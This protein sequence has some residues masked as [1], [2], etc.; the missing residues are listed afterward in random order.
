MNK[1]QEK[2][3]DKMLEH[4]NRECNAHYGIG[5]LPPGFKRA[6][7]EHVSKLIKEEYK[8]GYNDCLRK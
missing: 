4:N 7:K 1:E 2:E 5:K 6:I 3:F 8:K